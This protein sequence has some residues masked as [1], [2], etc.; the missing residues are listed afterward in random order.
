MNGHGVLLK[1][2]ISFLGCDVYESKKRILED[3]FSKAVTIKGTQR[4]HTIIPSTDRK[5][6]VDVK[7]ISSSQIVEQFKILKYM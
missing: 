1:T 7:T 5:N 6:Y 4:F 2:S 3:R